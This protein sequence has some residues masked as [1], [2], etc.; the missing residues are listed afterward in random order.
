[1]RSTLNTFNWI[2][3]QDEVENFSNFPD[4][5]LYIFLRS[6]PGIE[7]FASELFLYVFTITFIVIYFILMQVSSQCP[8][9]VPCKYEFAV[10]TLEYILSL[11]K[12]RKFYN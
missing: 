11:R 10:P 3:R 1:M 6:N 9:E 4:N 8:D 2:A 5:H 7:M 12:V